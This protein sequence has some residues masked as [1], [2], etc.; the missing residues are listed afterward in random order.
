MGVNGNEES[1]KW[2]INIRVGWINIF[3]EV[4]GRKIG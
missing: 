3:V 1:Y 4:G 2:L